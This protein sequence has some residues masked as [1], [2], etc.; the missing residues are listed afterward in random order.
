MEDENK[1]PKETNLLG[2]GLGTA[3]GLAGE[4]Y[5]SLT[6][7][8][9][10]KK[11]LAQL[12]KL[13]Y[14][15]EERKSKLDDVNKIYNTESLQALNAGVSSLIGILNSNTLKAIQN[16]KLLGAR[17]EALNKM[18]TQIDEY[19]RGIDLQKIQLESGTDTGLNFGNILFSGISGMNLQKLFK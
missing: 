19:N 18:D 12:D 8:S 3:F 15:E 7:A 6:A 16:S 2:F 5:S 4:L 13:K 9:K 17:S 1:D 10:L 11:A 14:D